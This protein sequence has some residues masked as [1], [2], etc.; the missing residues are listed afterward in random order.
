M[1][2]SNIRKS[3]NPVK[4]KQNNEDSANR[5]L[6]THGFPLMA[7]C[8][9]LCLAVLL[10]AL[11]NTILSAAIPRITDEFQSINSV[12]WYVSAYLLTTCAFQLNFGK[13]YTIFPMRPVFLFSVLVFE[14]GSAVCGAAPTSAVLILGRAIAG[15]GSAGIYSGALVMLAHSLFLVVGTSELT[16][17]R[18]RSFNVHVWYSG[19]HRS[20][21]GGGF[22]DHISWRW[23]FYINLPVGALSVVFIFVFVKPLAHMATSRSWRNTLF[24]DLDI[25]GSATLLPG[26]VALLL[27]LQWGGTDYAWSNG[28]II[29][30]FIL[31]A[32]KK[33][34][35]ATVPPR[36]ILHRSV[37]SGCVFSFL[38]GGSFYTMVYFLPLWFQ[39]IKEVSATKSGI[40]CIPLLLSMVV[41]TLLTGI[42]ITCRGCYVPFFYISAILSSIGA[43]L[44]TTLTMETSPAK[45]ISYQVIYGAGI[46]TGFQLAIVASQDVLS[47][48]DVPVGTA[49]VTFFLTLG[50]SIFTSV[51]ENVFMNKLI[52]SIAQVASEIDPLLVI[53]SGARD[54]RSSLPSGLLAFVQP[55]YSSALTMAWCVSTALSAASILG[56]IGIEWRKLK[57]PQMVGIA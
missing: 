27:A 7:L 22:T 54:L 6:Y 57:R 50:G 9:G 12:G 3:Q 45:W 39:T 44:L 47:L 26:V 46:G 35:I 23:C 38:L 52:S 15:T 31:S 19:S 36:I 28:R 32:R 42:T 1:H 25:P 49:L 21:A 53:H 18:H 2:S 4:L 13:L 33:G 20:S 11:D 10:V 8:I 14:A 40:M 43:G 17:I 30:L 16:P 37:L 5:D 29:T 51:G 41:L 34:D 55:I 56:A 24:N 48:E